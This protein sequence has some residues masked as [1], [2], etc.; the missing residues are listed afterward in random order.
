MKNDN[1]L[2]NL[3]IPGAGKSGTSSLHNYLNV[4]PDIYMSERKEPFYFN[5]LSLYAEEIEW[6]QNLFKEGKEQKYRGES[7]TAYFV[8]PLAI[9]RMKN[10]LDDPRFIIIL[11]NPISRLVSHY[12]WLKG[13]GLEYRSLIQA[14]KYYQKMPFNEYYHIRKHGKFYLQFSLY[15]KWVENYL[16]AFGRDKVFIITT[17]ALKSRPVETLN[18]CFNFLNLDKIKDINT[19]Q[20]FNVST[21]RNVPKWDAWFI[22]YLYTSDSKNSIFRYRDKIVPEFFK[23]LYWKFHTKLTMNRVSKNKPVISEEIKLWLK[24]LL[25]DDVKRLKEITKMEFDEWEEFC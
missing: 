22:H 3:F 12:F 11:R 14:V 16:K 1:F 15:S 8:S 21:F 2:P 6:Y 24:N 19:D 5:S 17:E 25:A 7:S 13:K 20:E 18:D 4:H 9:D 23:E 10:D